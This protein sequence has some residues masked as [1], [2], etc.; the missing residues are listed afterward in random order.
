M[1]TP[2]YHMTFPSRR[3]KGAGHQHVI[4]VIEY[5]QSTLIRTQPAPDGLHCCGLIRAP[6]FRQLQDARERR[7]AGYERL[8]R[9]GGSPKSVDILIEVPVGIFHGGLRFPNPTEAAQGGAALSDECFMKLHHHTLP[10]GKKRVAIREVRKH[11][12]QADR[13]FRLA[14][15]AGQ[16]T[17]RV[18]PMPIAFLIGN[19]R[20]RSQRLFAYLLTCFRSH[21]LIASA[22]MSCCDQ[23]FRLLILRSIA[24]RAKSS[25]SRC[26]SRNVCGTS[27]GNGISPAGWCTTG[28]AAEMG[29]SFFSTEAITVSAGSGTSA[30][31]SSLASSGCACTNCGFGVPASIKSR[32]SGDTASISDFL[33]IKVDLVE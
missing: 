21:S 26:G 16:T 27:T 2:E 33:F 7:I 20:E 32:A 12:F 19:L 29:I 22:T 30:V 17:D 9:I 23:G 28:A 8:V 18:F 11:R 3:E 4:C 13:A 5:Q 31:D 15:R 6:G 14:F 10:T 25:T 24:A 1:H